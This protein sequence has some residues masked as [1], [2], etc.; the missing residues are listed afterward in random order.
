MKKLYRVVL[1]LLIFIMII[2]W[3]PI[4]TPYGI[5]FNIGSGE[6]MQ[7]T[8]GKFD[9]SIHVQ[10]PGLAK[11]LK[12]YDIVSYESPNGYSVQKRLIALPGESIYITEGHIYINDEMID[13][14]YLPE[15][16]PY[17]N[18]TKTILGEDEYFFLGD[19][20]SK[21]LDSWTYGP[22]KEDKIISKMIY[23]F[24]IIK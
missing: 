20:R 21:S 14:P 4:L 18:D 17:Y 8:L 16:N 2:E 24:N 6:S 22:V 10:Y 11:D 13:E 7:P 15:I 5:F 9:I 12:R 19:N 23:N 3:I 1:G